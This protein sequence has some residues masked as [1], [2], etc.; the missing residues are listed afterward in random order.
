MLN[1]LPLILLLLTMVSGA[2]WFAHKYYCVA[3]RS[4]SGGN[5]QHGRRTSTAALAPA[6]IIHIAGFFPILALVLVF[7]SFMFEPFRIPSLSMSP[8]L[9]VGDFV[10]VNKFIYGLR[11]PVID[12]K[13]IDLGEP[14]KGDVMVFRHPIAPHDDLIKRVVGVPGDHLVYRNKRLSI[15]GKALSYAA[16]DDYHGEDYQARTEQFIE[17]LAGVRHRILQI[18]NRPAYVAGDTNF[19]GRENCIYDAE[20]FACTVP[21]NQYF[22]MGDSRD[23]SSDSRYWGFVP[24]ANII[25][26]AF[27]IWMNFHHLSQI[28]MIR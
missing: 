21:A 24:E 16:Q 17:D 25:G 3:Q 23:N 19:P 2:A 1:N 27:V 7:R 18:D 8:T 20:G 13:I 22:V 28:G 11:L 26:K 9:L 15:N 14:K 5:A 10:L 12:K 6:W 4:G